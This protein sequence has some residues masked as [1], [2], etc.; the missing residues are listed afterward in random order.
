MK[1]YPLFTVYATDEGK[2]HIEMD[3][4]FEDREC[5]KESTR[6]I[7]AYNEMFIGVTDSLISILIKAQEENQ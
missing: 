5:T 7:R 4:V 2:V 6:V 1:K 3:S